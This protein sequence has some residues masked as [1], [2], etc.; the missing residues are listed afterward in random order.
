MVTNQSAVDTVYAPCACSPLGKIQKVSAPYAVGGS[1]TAWTVYTYDGIGRTLT[2]QLPD[3]AST[4]TYSYSGNQTTVTDPAGKWKTFTSDVSGNLTTVVEPDPANQPGVERWL[5]QPYSYDWMKH[6]VGVS[7]PRGSTAQTRSFV[8]DAAGRLT[9][10]TNPENGTVTYTYNSDNTLQYKHD[11][12]GQDTVYTYDGTKRV[13]MIQRYPTGKTNAEDTAARV[14]YTYDTSLSG[15][16]YSQNSTGRLTSA[17]YGGYVG[18]HSFNATELYTYHPAGGVT[19]EEAIMTRLGAIAILT[20]ESVGERS[21][22][23]HGTQP[24]FEVASVKPTAVEK[25]MS[26]VMMRGGPGT[27]DPTQITYRARDAAKRSGRGV[28]TQNRTR[29]PAQDGSTTQPY[30]LYR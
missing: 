10:A 30:E 3:G 15:T 23:L 22:L 12:K 9:S 29:F 24:S 6:L 28:R 7:M 19:P 13:T 27:D 25:G 8:Y 4:T 17:T 11:A 14:T 5:L 18:G 1:P 20:L 21:R 2:T 16:T 26:H